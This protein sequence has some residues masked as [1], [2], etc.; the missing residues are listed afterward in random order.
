LV[1]V[2]LNVAYPQDIE[3]NMTMEEGATNGI[4]L[5]RCAA[6]FVRIDTVYHKYLRGAAP[7]KCLHFYPHQS[8]SFQKNK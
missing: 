4:F 5:F 3:V 8:L 6:P 2:Y 7:E 1:F